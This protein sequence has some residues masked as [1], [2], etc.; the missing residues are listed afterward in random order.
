M[1]TQVQPTRIPR[2]SVVSALTQLR[3]EWEQAAA[4]M[5]LM[6]IEAS[7]GLL[8]ADVANSIGLSSTEQLQA[9]GADLASELQETLTPPA[10]R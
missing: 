6:G 10:S 2:T 8:L 4:G 1:L 7:V 9:F 3:Q 5:S